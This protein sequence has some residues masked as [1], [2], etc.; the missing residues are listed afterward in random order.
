MYNINIEKIMENVPVCKVTVR[1]K[2]DYNIFMVTDLHV[3]YDSF[4]KVFF[5]EEVDEALFGDFHSLVGF[6]ESIIG[7]IDKVE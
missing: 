5:I 1:M 7:E 4:R 6:V 2:R 3:K